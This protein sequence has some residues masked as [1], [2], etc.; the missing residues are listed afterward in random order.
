MRKKTRK[1]GG[2]ITKCDSDEPF[3]G[4]RM[5][6]RHQPASRRDDL[7]FGRPWARVLADTYGHRPC[8]VPNVVEW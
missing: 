3:G 5:D 2:A 1:S 8:Y 4:Q 7:S 6:K